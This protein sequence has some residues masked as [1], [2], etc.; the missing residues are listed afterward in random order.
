MSAYSQLKSAFGLGAAG[1][2]ALTTLS[3][4]VVSDNPAVNAVATTATVGT[5]ASLF[6]YSLDDG[7]YYDDRYN[8]M[9]RGY[10]PAYNARVHRI[11]SMHD[12]RRRYPYNNAHVIQQ[13]RQNRILQQR[14][15]QQ[16]EHNRV[17]Q[18]RLE[19]E[20]NQ[21][22]HMRRN[23]EEQHRSQ[24]FRE[25]IQH[26]RANH[27]NTRYR[28]EENPLRHHKTNMGLSEHLKQQRQHTLSPSR[29]KGGSSPSTQPR[30]PWWED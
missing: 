24:R 12:Y 10:R 2:I 9:P 26:Q 16:R 17:L 8:R 11:D 15:E 14:I 30:R 21:N 27:M 23:M 25:Q 1:I 5:I 6:Y 29:H 13:Q 3:G 4:C 22:L 28:V 7:Y 19:R 18:N 20:R